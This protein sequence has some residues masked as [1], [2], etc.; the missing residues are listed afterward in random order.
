MIWSEAT[1]PRARASLRQTILEIRKAMG[2]DFDAVFRLEGDEIGAIENKLG[3]DVNCLVS[4]LEAGSPDPRF[5]DLIQSGTEILPFFDDI[6]DD[7]AEWLQEQRSVSSAEILTALKRLLEENNRD[8]REL[9][10]LAE[11]AY[12]IDNLDEDAARA[13]MNCYAKLQQSPKALKIY[14][15]LFG[16]LEDELGAEPSL[17]TQNLA[18]DIKLSQGSPP[19]SEARPV[20]YAPGTCVTVAV[21][22]FEPLYGSTEP[23]VVLGLLDAITSTLAGL[24]APAVISSNT[25]RR[26]LGSIPS[27]QQVSKELGVQY[28]VLGSIRADE[29]AATISVQLVDA[30]SDRIV[31]AELYQCRREEIAVVRSDIAQNIASALAPNL[32]QAELTRTSGLP[33]EELEPFHMVLRAKELIFEMS[34]TSFIEAGRLLQTALQKS[35]YF[36]PA[37][38]LMAEWCSICIWQGWSEDPEKDHTSLISAARRAIKLS[39]KEGRA[40]A[41][42]GHNQVILSRRYDDAERLFDRALKVL[43][44]DS[45]TLIWT[46]PSLAFSGSAEDAVTN[47]EKAMALSP[48]DPFMFRNQ[49][50]LSIAH[51]AMGDYGRAAHLGR[52]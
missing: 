36:A 25:T 32:N 49:H 37:H 12:K 35:P 44:N 43:P 41:L 20:L 7:Y 15:E 29:N 30:D 51:Y 2:E 38:T 13:L 18:V 10:R 3:T 6:G 46:V 16:R 5:L 23:F 50:F 26:Y 40:M 27:S 42:L 45:E 33:V 47:G 8:S 24:T 31:W 11:V 21:V 22:P 9:L 4:G 1:L 39:A 34:R 17:E 28:V 19:Q 52:A 14:T 48:H